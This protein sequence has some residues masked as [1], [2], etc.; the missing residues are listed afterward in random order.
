[1]TSHIM[2]VHRCLAWHV[3]ELNIIRINAYINMHSIHVSCTSTHPEEMAA[4]GTRD[5]GWPVVVLTAAHKPAGTEQKWQAP[6]VEGP[7]SLERT[8]SPPIRTYPTEWVE[9]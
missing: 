4:T 5:E 6:D 8:T 2:V 9:R 3:N 7:G 1:M